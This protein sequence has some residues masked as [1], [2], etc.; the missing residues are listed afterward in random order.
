MPY[1]IPK[2]SIT[3]AELDGVGKSLAE[4]Y[5]IA[6]QE[7]VRS[8]VDIMARKGM[9]IVTAYLDQAKD[10][11]ANLR[12]NSNDA[13]G[14]K[15]KAELKL[16][17][18]EYVAFKS[19]VAS[20]LVTVGEK[21]VS[22]LAS[23]IPIPLLGTVVSTVVS[24]AA[25]KVQEELH[26]A[27]IKD[28]DEQ[29]ATKPGPAP[30][31]LWKTDAEAAAYIQKSMNQYMLICKYIKTLPASIS[32]FDD[33][34]TF[35]AATFKVQAAASEAQCGPVLGESV[36]LCHAGTSGEDSGRFAGLHRQSSQRDARGGE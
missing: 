6:W 8:R 16:K 34:V 27:G 25:D 1:I 21:A 35:P 7:G 20:V 13:F 14:I 23:K 2:Y 3:Q 36:S 22:A 18:S 26:K 15:F 33:A 4:Y 28:A 32:T 9:G 19:D 29:L 10:T 17:V 5:D 30:E 11:Y 31:K 12:K 24:F